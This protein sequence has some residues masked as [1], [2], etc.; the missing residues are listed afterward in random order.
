MW[1]ELY[2]IYAYD[3]ANI[4]YAG[5]ILFASLSAYLFTNLGEKW[6]KTKTAMILIAT[7]IASVCITS[8]LIDVMTWIDKTATSNSDLIG[9]CLIG[10]VCIFALIG[11]GAWF[12]TK[13]EKPYEEA[14]MSVILYDAKNGT[15]YLKVFDETYKEIDDKLKQ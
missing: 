3:P 9:E 14:R 6:K 11:V 15:N 5:F 4:L 12:Q 1:N 7:A 10:A 13:S 2:N 8:T